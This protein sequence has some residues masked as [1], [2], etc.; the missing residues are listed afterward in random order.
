MPNMLI[1]DEPTNHLDIPSIEAI[2]I[3]LNRFGG[4]M[5]VISHDKYFLRNIG[6]EDFYTIDNEELKQDYL[7]I[8]YK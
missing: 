6:I 1:L 2:E 5:I 3:A 8:G 7:D 4:A